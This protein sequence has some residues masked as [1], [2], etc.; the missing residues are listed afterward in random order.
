[1]TTLPVIPPLAIRTFGVLSITLGDRMEPL[2]FAAHS[3]EALLVY[4][5]CQDR[6][7]GREELAELLWPERT[8]E[9]S[10]MNLRGAIYRLRGQV[11]PYLLITRQQLALNADANV[12]LDARQFERYLAAGELG[13]GGC[14]LPRRL[15]RGLLSRRQ[16]CRLSSGRCWN[17]NGCAPWRLSAV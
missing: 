13:K 8:Q 17:G 1:M 5:A 7:L 10:R 3:V 11:E 4:L 15:S 12:D 9:Q 6:P 14:A 16:P 2:R